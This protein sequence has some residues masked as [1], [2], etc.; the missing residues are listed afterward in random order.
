M[1]VSFYYALRAG[2]IPVRMSA[3]LT[4]QR[5]LRAG[6]AK[7]SLV[8]FYR[9]CR[10]ILVKSETYFDLYDRVFAQY[11][12][13]VEEELSD[14]LAAELDRAIAD[15]LSD[16]AVRKLFEEI[17]RHEMP[18]DELLR[19]FQERLAEQD[20]RHDGGRKW[21]GTQGRSPFGHGGAARRGVRVGGGAQSF[22]AVKV[23]GERRWKDLSRVEVIR[24]QQMGEVLARLKQL[25]QS[26]AKTEL[27]VDET[28]H[29][30]VR[31]AGEIEPVFR[32]SKR[33]R[34]RLVLLLDNG[35]W[36]M[37]PYIGLVAQLFGH[38]RES[39]RDL[40]TYFFHNCVYEHVFLDPARSRPVDTEDVLRL[41]PEYR[42]VVVGDASM[43]PEELDAP[44]GAIWRLA[45]QVPPGRV[46]LE[47][48]GERFTRR[49][50][51][52]PIPR[53]MWR[54]AYGAYTIQRIGQVFPMFDLTLGGIE[55]AV[56]HLNDGP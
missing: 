1:F 12:D 27:D 21:I 49:A 37:D 19:R 25:V 14:E 41:D 24:D 35:G 53:A 51:L 36:S 45:G 56:Q 7:G 26:G 54:R 46:W 10:S 8:S 39:V 6:L 3:F 31:L 30:T 40:K 55:A 18:L 28:I 44:G 9:I 50:W 29:E 52:N 32:R 20:G 2:G 22:S 33:N 13:G 17:E 34:V 23:A 4:L 48:L 15:W 43:A 47:R 5:A 38:V 42:V 11:F 16:P